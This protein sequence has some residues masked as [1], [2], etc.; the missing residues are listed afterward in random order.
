MENFEGVELINIVVG[1]KFPLFEKGYEQ[2]KGQEYA[3]FEASEFN[4]GYMFCAYIPHPRGYEIEAFRKSP[5]QMR[6]VKGDGMV[7]P[8][9]KIGNQLIYEIIFDPTLYDD[10]RALQIVDRN[11]ILTLFLIDSNTGMLLA[12]RQCNFPLKMIQMCKEVWSRAILD[13]NFS[14]KFSN[15]HK[16]LQEK[17][18]LNTM[19]ERA[20]YVGKMGETYNLDEIK[21]PNQKWRENRNEGL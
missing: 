16:T 13:I 10:D 5:I 17:Y 15:W 8:M 14:E 18:S 9:I 1:Q 11:N 2:H 12:I 21:T 6:I 19:W 3:V 20:L 7:I 4:Q